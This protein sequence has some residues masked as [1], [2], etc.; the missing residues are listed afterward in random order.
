[1][2]TNPFAT[3][4]PVLP[5]LQSA[6]LAAEAASSELWP[7]LP[8]RAARE[9][10]QIEEGPTAHMRK[11]PRPSGVRVELHDGVSTG[12]RFCLFAIRTP[13]QTPFSPSCVATLNFR[14]L[15][16]HSLL[17]LAADRIW[18]FQKRVIS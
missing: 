18:R 13:S 1:M 6:L 4:L 16:L 10:Y 9:K 2:T 14:L 11:R 12:P 17:H 3:A 8:S 5:F 15:S 7:P